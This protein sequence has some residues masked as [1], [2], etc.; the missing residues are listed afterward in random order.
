MTFHEVRSGVA[1]EYGVVGRDATDD[2]THEGGGSDSRQG[3]G[4]HPPVKVGSVASVQYCLA[5]RPGRTALPSFS[6]RIP[7]R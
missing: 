5:R 6:L 2:V 3:K 4:S 7:I 1:D